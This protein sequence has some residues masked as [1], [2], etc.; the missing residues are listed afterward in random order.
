MVIIYRR[1][2]TC[3]KLLSRQSFSS[4]IPIFPS[5]LYVSL[6]I[7][8]SRSG[9]PKELNLLFLWIVLQCWWVLAII[10]VALVILL[11]V[12]IL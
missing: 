7:I 12:F 3:L 5:V 1:E 2:R 6:F 4:S 8:F 11:L 9:L 10:V